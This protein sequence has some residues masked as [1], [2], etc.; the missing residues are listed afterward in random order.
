MNMPSSSIVVPDKQTGRID[1]WLVEQLKI[2][3]SHLQHLIKD[4]L[5][6]V[7][8]EKTKANYQLEGGEKIEVIDE[9]NLTPPA[10]AKFKVIAE[11]PDFLVIYKPVGVIAHPAPGSQA[12]VLSS[13]LLSKYPELA[14]VGDP[15]RPGIVHRLDRDVSGLMVIARTPAMYEHLKNEF[16]LRRISKRYT[17]LV[18]GVIP[19]SEGTLNFSLGRSKR[20]GRIAARPAGE[21]GRDSITKFVVKE[22]YAHFTLLDIVL[23]T[24]RTH[25]I[26]AHFFAYRHPLVGDTI[27]GT[28]V[29]GKIKDSGL[30][31]PFL[32]ATYLGFNDLAGQWQEYTVPLDKELVAFL[33]KI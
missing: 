32:E 24:G 25:Q 14:K 33:D 23:V 8:G 7:D 2:S 15:E 9:S 21:P 10:V 1:K 31:R 30:G 27:Y 28:K 12:P 4:G 3:R 19:D 29:G 26:R 18:Q 17:G 6:L 13:A 20:T 5:V 22:K 11:S 16:K